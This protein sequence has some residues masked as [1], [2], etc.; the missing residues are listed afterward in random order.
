[1]SLKPA[2]AVAGLFRRDLFEYISALRPAFIRSPG[3]NYLEGHGP[4]TRWD[5]KV[6]VGQP[7]ARRG[8]YNSAWGY[9]EPPGIKPVVSDLVS[10]S[11][12][13]LLSMRH[14]I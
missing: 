8:H 9:C 13:G 1:M 5:W 3:G 2:D 11:D 14:C 10:R 6:T 7:E 4:R 12:P